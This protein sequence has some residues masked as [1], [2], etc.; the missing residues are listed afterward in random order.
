M[1]PVCHQYVTL[2]VGDSFRTPSLGTHTTSTV[3][4]TFG[5]VGD[6]FITPPSVPPD[7]LSP[8][9]QVASAQPWQ[10]PS[11]LGAAANRRR[12]L[13]QQPRRPSQQA[14]QQRE[15]QRE[16]SAA[17]KALL[18]SLTTRCRIRRQGD[19]LWRWTWRS[20]QMVSVVVGSLS[21]SLLV[22]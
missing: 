14:Q 9:Q 11:P 17:G 5:V 2:E 4:L 13:Q 20:R 10:G 18:P 21:S 8:L 3:V 6:S 22:A 1:S 16:R 12:Q 15:R 19:Q 7:M